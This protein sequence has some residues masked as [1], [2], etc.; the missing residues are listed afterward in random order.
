MR[1]MSRSTGASS[2]KRR[3]KSMSRLCST[4][5][6]ATTTQPALPCAL[7]TDEPLD[8]FFDASPLAGQHAS[9]VEHSTRPLISRQG[10]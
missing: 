8:L 10:G 3:S 2:V 7:L 1:W 6:V 9:V 4:T 5:C